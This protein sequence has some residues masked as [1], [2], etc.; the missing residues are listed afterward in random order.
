MTLATTTNRIAYSGNGVTTAFSFPYY[1][2]A[3]GDLVVVLRDSSGN[4]V[5]KTITTHY[6]VSGAGV[7]AG[8]T[9][10]MLTAPASG[11]S[12]TIYRDPS[13]LQ[14]L[15]LV[16][17]DALPAES[18]EQAFDKG[19][20]ISQ[21]LNDR[22]DR[23]VRWTD[24]V[25][26]S[27][28]T[29]LPS[30]LTADAVFKINSTGTGIEIASLNSIGTVVTFPLTTKGDLLAYSSSTARFGIGSDGQALVADSA[31]TFGMKWAYP[32]IV[33]KTA[34]Y[35]LTALDEVVCADATSG[36]F[37]LTIPAASSVSGKVFLIKKTDAS[38]NAISISA[39]VDGR[40]VTLASPAQVL[41]IRSD[42]TNWRFYTPSS[43]RISQYLAT[44]VTGS[45]PTALGEYRSFLRQVSASTYTET[46]GSPGTAPSSANGVLL[47]RGTGWGT[48][49]SN[50]QP[51]RYDIF[52]GKRKRIQWE[53]YST[54]GFTGHMNTD[55]HLR[56]TITI[57]GYR[58]SYDPTT[59]VASI[60]VP[61]AS[62]YTDT[63]DT[64]T[65]DTGTYISSNPYFDIIVSDI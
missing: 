32:S 26:S 42:G 13:R 40:V 30:V 12:L 41:H 51:T 64:G 9:V 50:N 61:M 6:T 44:R 53:F 21:R 2:L 5:T 23:S 14:S 4:E 16:N 1:F 57:S 38:L 56:T 59:G 25:S 60:C 29:R 45:A 3:N 24:G 36:T 63:P 48:V 18:V 19:V 43:F 52:V 15:D 49:N 33:T 8:G 37:T 62:T 17:N 27:F 28:D 22:I 10:T 31:Q 58:K 46:N 11:E 47:Y 20:M 35:T 7:D 65:D 34:N 55:P 54:T 39:T